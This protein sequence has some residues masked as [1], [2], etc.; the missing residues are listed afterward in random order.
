[1]ERS[2]EGVSSSSTGEST[3]LP[4]QN[5]NISSNSPRWPTIDGAL[6]LSEEESVIYA[7]R[8]YKFGFLLLPWLWALN[9][10]YFWPVL[11]HSSSFPSFRRYVV[12][13]AVGFS[14]ATILLSSWALTF[15]IGGERLFG[16]VWN[17]LVMYNVADQLGLAGWM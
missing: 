10:F 13:S 16:P 11:R 15:S 9:C 1:M 2:R 8:F 5:P 7:R 3:F 17:Q 4:L 14:I 12:G 6:G